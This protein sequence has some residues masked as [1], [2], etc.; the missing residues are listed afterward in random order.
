VP[1]KIHKYRHL[2]SEVDLRQSGVVASLLV[3]A[4]TPEDFIASIP[5]FTEMS[6]TEQLPYLI[7]YLTQHA[8][9]AGVSATR[10]N[11]FRTETHLPS[12][13]R[14]SQFLSERTKK[15]GTA[16]ALFVRGKEGYVLT[17]AERSRIASIVTG[18]PTAKAVAEDLHNTM[19]A[20]VDADVQGYLEEA[21]GCF[22]HGFFRASIVF[23][24]CAAYSVFR[25][26][27]FSKH[28][29]ALNTEMA[30]WRTPKAIRSVDDFQEH[31][32]ATIVTTA[33]TAGILTKE[34]EK[35]L[36]SLL[37]ER[38]SFA[39]PSARTASSSIAEAFIEK[40]IKEVITI[41]G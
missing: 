20:I 6:A 39:H 41:Y 29:T 34:A 30:T 10:L 8:G 36:K 1:W 33:R 26:W 12:Y 4:S 37:D 7:Y 13:N 5:R 15:V 11:A 17:L 23:T 25:S 32:E 16:P 19:S 22:E 31:T 24:W 3:G 28:I 27:V 9:V 18:R 14:T 2:C 21:I 38:N 40:A 35:R